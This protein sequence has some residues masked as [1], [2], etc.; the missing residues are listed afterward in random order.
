MSITSLLIW[1]LPA[2]ALWYATWC[3]LMSFRAS[4]NDGI[5]P[6]TTMRC[7]IAVE[8]TTPEQA[9]D[10]AFHQYCNENA[11][12]HSERCSCRVCRYYSDAL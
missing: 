7:R 11:P 2:M 3:V 4:P 9:W 6:R 5:D 8:D 10:E 1:L 12:I